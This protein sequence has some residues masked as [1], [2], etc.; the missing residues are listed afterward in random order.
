M[1]PVQIDDLFRFKLIGDA[2]ISPDGRRIAYVLKEL[3]RDADEYV[4]NIYVHED[5][6]SRR[7]T[8]GD[9]D[10]A[11]R[12]SPDGRYL[13]F[14]SGREE[15][16][17]IYLMPACAG[18]PV[19]LTDQ[20]LGAGAPV[21]S[22]DST[23]IAFTA[24]VS[25]KDVPAEDEKKAKTRV[26]ERAVY[27]LNG[28]GYTG[29]RRRHLFVL[30]LPSHP[31]E[32]P[33]PL[34]LTRGDFNHNA[35]AWSP[36]GAH[37]AFAADR[38]PDWDLRSYSDIWVIPV[39][40]GEPRRVTEA[41][42]LWTNPVFSPDG[43]HIALV[44]Y[45]RPVDRP[46]VYFPQLWTVSRG[47]GE[48]QNCLEGIDVVVGN[49]VGSDWSA[50]GEDGLA[51]QESG[52]YF[53]ASERGT[54]NVYRWEDGLHPVTRGAQNVMD[55][56]VAGCGT[57]AYTASRATRPSEIFRRDV[58]G[59][60]AEEVAPLTH[61]NDEALQEISPIP[62]EKLTFTGAEGVP[63]EG[64]VLKPAGFAEGRRYPLIV[65]IHGG[66]VS[67]YGETF[68]HEFQSLAGQGFGVF[69]CN[70]RGSSSYGAEFQMGI[71]GDWGN[72]D[73]G[74]LMSGVDQV[75]QLPWVDSHRLGVAGGSYGGF[76]VNWITGHT[77]RF[78]A[79]CTQRSIANHISQGG[80]SDWAATRGER[81]GGTPEEAPDFL[82]ERSPLKYVAN[83][84]TPTLIIHSERD[85]R[86]PLEEGE[87]WFAA[88]RRRHVPVR[89]VIFPE[90]NHDLSR[91]GKP[92]RRV[93]RLEHIIRWFKTYL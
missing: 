46:A 78:A 45:A 47:G 33:E 71:V 86:C 3:D 68:F 7:F 17:Q 2:Q 13:A 83:V 57:V 1:R 73:Y 40:G 65:Y 9:K 31:G 19:R 48:P 87:Q 30:S 72:L 89:F 21:W 77:D 35:P 5:G 50:A 38:D 58:A 53:I 29:D 12:W 93:E 55:F 69:Y 32:R 28:V 76:M 18:E 15:K 23:R 64:W 80:T 37:L 84:T 24:P 43:S 25:T 27:K 92:S 66:P 16:A 4:S 39:T 20:T 41:P 44:G 52:I 91:A 14:L 6:E 51:W 85:D 49:S 75:A 60:E 34:Q 61:H 36:D 42:G 88:L 90:E 59:A 79:A 81:L 74:D 54:A 67:A 10:S 11:P 63:V 70:P 56:S 82:W 8:A 22:P 62:P 26:I